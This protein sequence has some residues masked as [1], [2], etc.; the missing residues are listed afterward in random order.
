MVAEEETPE[1]SRAVRIA[2][3]DSALV[4]GDG[5]LTQTFPVGQWR[6]QRLVFSAATRAEASRIGTGAQLVVRFLAKSGKAVQVVHSGAPV[7]S[8]HWIRHE[9][10]AD[11]PGKAEQIQ[12]CLVVTGGAAGWFG[13]IDLEV[14]AV[15]GAVAVRDDDESR[16]RRRRSA[17]PWDVL[18][19][20]LPAARQLRSGAA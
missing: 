20:S 8:S 1:A 4:W 12:I 3:G 11:I 18:P 14:K 16:P 6:R 5:L 9:I 19:A 17:R 13:D 7:R 15:E 2:R 10:A